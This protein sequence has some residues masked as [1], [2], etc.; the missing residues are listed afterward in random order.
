MA[1]ALRARLQKLVPTVMK[2]K[3]TEKALFPVAHT[4]TEGYIG[5]IHGVLFATRDDKAT[6]MK[7]WV[8]FNVATKPSKLRVDRLF[9]HAWIARGGPANVVDMAKGRH[10]VYPAEFT[11][12][13]NPITIFY[14]PQNI[15]E[16]DNLNP[17]AR[18][19]TFTGNILV[20][21][22][23]D[24]EVPLNI[25]IEE[26]KAIADVVSFFSMKLSF[27]GFKRGHSASLL[28][29][30]SSEPAPKRPRE[31]SPPTSASEESKSAE[32]EP[33]AII[34]VFGTFDLLKIIFHDATAMDVLSFT[35]TS[36]EFQEIGRRYFRTQVDLGISVFLNP[37]SP[38]VAELEKEMSKFWGTL[39]KHHS[40]VHGSM[41]TYAIRQPSA[42]KKWSPNNLNIVVPYD[43]VN[44]VIKSFKRNAPDKK[45]LS[46]RPI[47]VIRYL[48]TVISSIWMIEVVKD[49][50]DRFGRTSPS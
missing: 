14:T 5:D 41:V 34:R 20:I 43:S 37:E 19:V 50:I 7:V 6:G 42:A 18:G 22:H 40:I 17:V 4:D 33:S 44:T 39:A 9:I 26:H 21:K 2:S 29:F 35:Q 31:T 3:K 1:P 48:R 46:K 30:G 32:E 13:T 38:P 10:T 28:S 49:S 47:P 27:S 11:A 23:T 16:L 24:A 15:A 36:R 8:P 45:L 25:E 12:L